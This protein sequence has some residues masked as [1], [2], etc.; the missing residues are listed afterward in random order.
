MTVKD[1]PAIIVA[2]GLAGVL[3]G[4]FPTAQGWFLDTSLT[5]M[6]FELSAQSLGLFTVTKLMFMPALA[7]L[8]LGLVAMK[9]SL[10]GRVLGCL[11][12]LSGLGTLLSW[13]I[14]KTAIDQ[15][16]IVGVGPA[17]GLFLMLVSGIGALL[18]GVLLL[19]WPLNKK[20]EPKKS[21]T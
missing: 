5:F 2:S 16:S 6:D 10:A 7:T 13:L 1:S 9:Q 4:A 11:T 3:G 19:L 21:E 8:V 17:F 15:L 18:G 12:I 20:V 14:Q